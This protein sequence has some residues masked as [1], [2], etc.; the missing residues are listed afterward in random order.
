MTTANTVL[1]ELHDMNLIRHLVEPSKPPCD[2]STLIICILQESPQRCVLG[3][4]REVAVTKDQFVIIKETVDTM[5]TQMTDWEK[6]LT[7]SLTNKWL[8]VGKYQ[9][10]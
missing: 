7:T 4:T 5:E 6:V 8:Y 1:I 3:S 9:G 2:V 10:C